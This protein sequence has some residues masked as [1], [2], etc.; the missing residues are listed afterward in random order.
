[1]FLQILQIT[2]PVFLLAAAGYA[3]AWRGLRFDIEF[4]T[5]LGVTFSMPCLIFA[6]LAKV[7]IDPAVF[8]ATAAASLVAY[9]VLSLVLWVS[10]RIAGLNTRTYLAPGV[11]ANTGNVGLPVAMFAYGQDGLAFGIVIFA[12]MAILS[13][14]V[15][16]YMV[17]GRGRFGEVLRQPLVYAA[18]LGGV[19]ALAGW[20]LPVWLQNALELAGQISIPLML[21]TLGVSIA[22]LTVGA[23]GRALMLAL[24]K[25]AISAAVAVGVVWLFG[26]SGPARGV[27]VLQLI[28]PVAVT[29]YLIAERYRTEPDTVAGTVVVST[30]VSVAAIPAAL[31]LLLE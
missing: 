2:A 14:T 28:M 3:W 25:L 19:F 6:V 5:R 11:F 20:K 10:L 12:V 22:K 7:D 24:A 17:A 29:S 31:A 9:A 27:L 8:R 26:L 15:G 23:V 13:F 16:I 1:M 18:V 21:L 30:L 4:V